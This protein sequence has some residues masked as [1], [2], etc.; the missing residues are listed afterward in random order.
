MLNAINNH[1]TALSNIGDV[2]VGYASANVSVADGTATRL[3]SVYLP[4]GT[5][6]VRGDVCWAAKSGGYRRANIS[7]TDKDLSV[8]VQDAVN[9]ATVIQQN[10]TEIF[11]SNGATFYLNVY[12][13][14]G[15]T[16]TVNAGNS[17]GYITAM[18]AV[19]IK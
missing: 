17:A 15:S 5:W 3:C 18:R 10:F 11:V 12:Q 13:S 2:V 9:L 7:T 6:V 16:I 19:R 14:S 8:H 1:E 4:K